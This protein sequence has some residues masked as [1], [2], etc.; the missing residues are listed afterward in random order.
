MVEAPGSSSDDQRLQVLNRYR[1]LSPTPNPTLDGLVRVAA[2]L[3]DTPIAFVG[4]FDTEY[5]VIKA[6]IGWQYARL[7]RQASLC[8]QTIAQKTLIILE[9][10]HKHPD[11][12]RHPIIELDAEIRFYAGVPLITNEG[13]AIGTLA[14]LDRR[15]RQLNPDQQ[16][17]LLSLGGMVL[18]HLNEQKYVQELR[19]IQR[20]QEKSDVELQRHALI[21]A[22]IHDALL[23]LDLGGRIIDCNPGASQLFGW[24]KAELF[25]KTLQHLHPPAV[26][27][28]R[29]LSVVKAILSAGGWQAQERFICK[30]G[31]TGT[32]QMNAV[33]LQSKG[34]QTIGILVIYHDVSD[35]YLAEL[36]WEQQKLALQ[37]AQQ[38]AQEANQA[39]G[40]FLAMISHEIRT[41]M[42]AVIGMTDLLKETPL[43]PDQRDFVDTIHT[44]GE[45]LLTII[46]QVLDFSKLESGSFKLDFYSF[47]LQEYVENVLDLLATKALEKGL[48]LFYRIAD[49]VPIL[50]EGD[51]NRVRQVLLNLLGNAL[52]FTDQGEVMVDV[53]RVEQESTAYPDTVMV[54]FAVKDTGIGISPEQQAKIFN[55]YAQADVSTA[56][57]YGGTGL[58][59][60]ISHRL[61]ELMGGKIWLKSKVGKGSTFFFAIPLRP[62]DRSQL[63]GSLEMPLAA[64]NGKHILIIDQNPTIQHF[65]SRQLEQ[66]GMIPYRVS[67]WTEEIN[68]LR[69]GDSIDMV[70]LDWDLE[71]SESFNLAR[72]MHNLPNYNHLPIILLHNLEQ[73]N[74]ADLTDLWTHQLEFIGRLCKPIKPKALKNVLLLACRSH[75]LVTITSPPSTYD[76][77]L[78]QK[79]PLRILLAEDNLINQKVIK[80]ILYR[81]GYTIKIVQNGYQVLHALEEEQCDLILMDLYMPELDG[82][83][84]TRQICEL[85]SP[86]QRPRIVALTAHAL[87]SVET[88]CEEAGMNDYLTKPIRIPELIQVLQETAAQIAAQPKPTQEL[89]PPI[90][91]PGLQ[92]FIRDLAGNDWDFLKDLVAA[93]LHDSDQYLAELADYGQ[94]PSPADQPVMQRIIHTLKSSSNSMFAMTLGQ[95][96]QQFENE[97]LTYDAGQQSNAI[98]ALKQ[99]YKRVKAA[100]N[101][102]IYHS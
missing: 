5:Q 1:A 90:D 85:Y 75:T 45:S 100:L 77:T 56:R 82:L 66:W 41:P 69:R 86:Q 25:G 50:V 32:A 35:R 4:F 101:A 13:L 29:S 7:P 8:T 89:R 31:T 47:D 44:A 53:S 61:T 102:L 40:E 9:D 14:V 6:S 70:L 63:A 34:K 88:E 30:D 21:F 22:H 99:E 55:P 12:R 76:R 83:Q 37:K 58:G 36:A 80:Q 60:N 48:G 67:S 98:Q 62:L 18:T 91:I 39:K 27:T 92:A 97:W 73:E 54:Q 72:Q 52:K 81:L 23:V 84:T 43:S 11:F 74:S 16:D 94:N 93:Y 51:G 57:N 33:P 59:L 42:N 24:S 65:L 78:G 26:E 20:Q 96:C 79:Y 87:S 71:K 28:V 46:N 68:H 10:L 17:S 64:L 2:T 3:C 49:N 19:Q 15:P 38:V 95:M